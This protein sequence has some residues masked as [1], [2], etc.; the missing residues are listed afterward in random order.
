[1]RFV[2]R[3]FL[4]ALAAFGSGCGKPAPNVNIMLCPDPTAGCRLQLGGEGV[5]VR[6]SESPRAMRPFVIEVDAPRAVAVVADFTMPGM[7][8]VPNRYDLAR[9][10]DG[11][12]RAKVVLPVCISGRADWSLAVT[13]GDR[14]A[15]VPF[16][17]GK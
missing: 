7:D 1:M 10:P 14:T 13:V 17:V 6:F 11:Q 8:M 3:F 9:A 15:S 5:V 12:W 16:S 4:V 2:S